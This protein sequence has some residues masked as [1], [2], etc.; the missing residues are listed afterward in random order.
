MVRQVQFLK[1]MLN[2]YLS[3][4]VDNV[5]RKT[6]C[7]HPS[8][9]ASCPRLLYESYLLS[10]HES[11]DSD[12]RVKR[13]FDNGRYVHQRIQNYYREIG[14]LIDEDVPIS[15]EKYE[16][17]GE[18]DGLLKFWDELIV[19][20]VKS[21]NKNGF[22]NLYKPSYGY[23]VQLNVYM[24]CLGLRYGILLYECKDDQEVAE[25]LVEYNESILVPIFQKLK[26]VQKCIQLGQVPP[27]FEGYDCYWCSYNSSCQESK[28]EIN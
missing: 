13:I 26:Y 15:D 4:R 27:R 8:S 2:H 24:Y 7:F 21:I 16:I 14:V 23:I 1:P 3:Q 20:D 12:P 10:T 19:L 11:S 22:R 17:C 28:N 5:G 9:L 6:G 18:I 25:F